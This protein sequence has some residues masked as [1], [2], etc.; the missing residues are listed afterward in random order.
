MAGV[1]CKNFHVLNTI[2]MFFGVNGEGQ[3]F[4]SY[5]FH[6]IDF[7]LWEQIDRIHIDQVEEVQYFHFN[8]EVKRSEIKAGHLYYSIVLTSNEPN[9]YRNLNT[10][11]FLERNSW[12]NMD[13][14]MRKYAIDK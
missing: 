8:K 12:N 4:I 10:I 14:M 13:E 11:C 6:G 5:R 3:F 9:L 2:E 7:S 1:R